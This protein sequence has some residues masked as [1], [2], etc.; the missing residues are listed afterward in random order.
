[1]PNLLNEIFYNKDT[2][3]FKM[4]QHFYHGT[5]MN[6]ELILKEN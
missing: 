5:V 3:S 6:Q 2:T 4:F 1:M